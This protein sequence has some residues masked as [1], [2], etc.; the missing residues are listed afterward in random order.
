MIAGSSGLKVTVE[1]NIG[2]YE[3]THLSADADHVVISYNPTAGARSRVDAVWQLSRELGA[4]GFKADIVTDLDDVSSRA[5]ELFER[6]RLRAIVGAGG[7]GTAAELI[8]RTPSGV[9]YAMLPGGTENLLSKY[10]DQRR[11]V[12]AV[13][14]VIRDGLVTHLDAGLMTNERYNDGRLFMLMASCGIDAEVVHRIAANRTGH[15]H[16]LSYIKPIWESIRNY[17]YPEVRVYFRNEQAGDFADT[18]RM[19]QAGWVVVTNL[20][21]YARGLRFAPEAVGTDG[22]FDLCTFREG[23]FFSGLKYLSGVAFGQHEKLDDCDIVKATH[24]RIESDKNV[25]IQIDG[26]P[27]GTSPAHIRIEPSRL[28]LLISPEWAAEQ[29]IATA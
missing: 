5:G 8:N 23:S 16:H 27:G 20:P 11:G 1:Q 13:V 9:P 25:P 18:W 26:D 28:S 7:D 4:A 2:H 15:I 19:V 22:Q 29:G 17:R 12:A 14:E 21:R 3:T 10:L 6:G 24:I